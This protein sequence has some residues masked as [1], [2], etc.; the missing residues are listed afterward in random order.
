VQVIDE[1]TTVALGAPAE[2][3]ADPAVIESYLGRGFL[4]SADA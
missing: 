3:Q 2:V 4:A 1:G